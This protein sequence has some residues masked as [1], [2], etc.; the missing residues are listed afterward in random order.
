MGVSYVVI[1]FLIISVLA[2]VG[3]TSLCVA[4]YKNMYGRYLDSRVAEH[5][6]GKK[7]TK[8]M[9]PLRVALICILSG[10]FLIVLFWSVLLIIFSARLDADDELFE[11]VPN[12]TYALYEDEDHALKHQSPEEDM[13]G[14]TRYVQEGRERIIYYI[15]DDPNTTA[16]QICYYCDTDLPRFIWECRAMVDQNIR[17]TMSSECSQETGNWVTVSFPYVFNPEKHYLTTMHFIVNGQDLVQIPMDQ[18]AHS[19]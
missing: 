4:V 5:S 7:K 16:P 12:F 17:F 2:V 18:V 6:L 15:A 19:E 3:I 9:S 13:P 1:F 10:F 14:Y 8:L 11:A